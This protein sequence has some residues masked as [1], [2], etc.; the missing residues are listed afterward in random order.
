[1]VMSRFW[2]RD[3]LDY[4]IPNVSSHCHVDKRVWHVDGPNSK[5]YDCEIGP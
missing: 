1:M 3:H 5:Y 2:V 4:R